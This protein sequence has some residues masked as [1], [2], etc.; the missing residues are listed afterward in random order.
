VDEAAAVACE[1]AG[2]RATLARE[3]RRVIAVALDVVESRA[4]RRTDRTASGD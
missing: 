2:R 4:E 1:A 3:P